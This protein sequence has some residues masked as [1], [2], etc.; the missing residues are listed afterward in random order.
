VIVQLKLRNG[1]DELDL[2]EGPMRVASFDIGDPAP[3]EVVNVSPAADGTI[4]T[5][6]LVGERSVSMLIKMF[7][8]DESL[9]AQYAS[10]R[11]FT[12]VKSRPTLVF[13]MD[14]AAPEVQLTKL[15]HSGWSTQTLDR[16]QHL[17]VVQWVTDGSSVWESTTLSSSVIYPGAGVSS[18]GL[19]FDVEFDVEFPAMDAVGTG[20][21]ANAGNYAAYPRLRVYGPCGG[22][23]A[24][25][26]IRLMNIT[27]GA[28]L[29]FADLSI[30]AGNYLE[31][32]TLTK[33]I[34]LNS[35]AAQSRYD[36]LVLAD[37][38]WWTLA[39][40]DNVVAF[41]P[42]TWSGAAQMQISHRSA[43]L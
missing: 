8:A 20:V 41:R 30:T 12:S 35:D 42:D 7:T 25:E 23:G 36:K 27:S 26:L 16:F 21:V 1:A 19:E 38:E 14:D 4:D 43:W 3:R 9:W 17:A 6:A 5:T 29:V 34:R 11:R 13:Q 28:S 24:S 22:A 15:R 40:G 33:T 37:S 2:I 31:V 32:D 10:L 39:P 18:A